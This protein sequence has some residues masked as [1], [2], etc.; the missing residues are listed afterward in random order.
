MRFGWLALVALAAG[1]IWLAGCVPDDGSSA[2]GGCDVPFESAPPRRSLRSPFPTRCALSFR[3]TS[4]NI[5]RRTS[6]RCSRAKAAWIATR[7]GASG[8]WDSRPL[9]PMGAGRTRPSRRTTWQFHLRGLLNY[10]FV[11]GSR[12]LAVLRGNDGYDDGLPG[13]LPHES[14]FSCPP[15]TT[16]ARAAVLYDAF[17]EWIELERTTRTPEG[18]GTHQAAAG[19]FAQLCWIARDRSEFP[20]GLPAE[21]A[22]GP[23][24]HLP[25]AHPR[26]DA[27]RPPR[28]T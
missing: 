19:G 27:A 8:C 16:P 4:S 2:A 9:N 5:S 12:A 7:A 26:P 3:R 25:E 1:A 24:A 6:S 10:E 18:V 14:G 11:Q 17:E 20:H 23:A 13:V 15:Q 22:P 28:S 21:G